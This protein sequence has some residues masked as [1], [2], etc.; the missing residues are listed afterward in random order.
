M[1]SIIKIP[2]EQQSFG[3]QSC[4]RAGIDVGDSMSYFNEK[5]LPQRELR[6]GVFMRAVA[7]KNAMMTIFEF[8]PNTVIPVHEHPHEQISYVIAGEM[9]FS[10]DGELKRLHPGEGVIISSHQKH[11]ARIFDTPTKVIDVWHPQREEYLA[12]LPRDE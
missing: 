7:G 9:E 1:P 2:I 10:L 12:H 4:R 5:E 3:G 8:Q 11:G 6:S